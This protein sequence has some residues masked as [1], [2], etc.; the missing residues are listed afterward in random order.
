MDDWFNLAIPMDAVVAAFFLQW[1]GFLWL[2][3][4]TDTF[5][6]GFYTRNRKRGIILGAAMFCLWGPI[7]LM[8]V[9]YGHSPL[10]LWGGAS[11]A[12]SADMGFFGKS[13]AILGWYA[14]LSPIQAII[15]IVLMRR[16]GRVH[17]TP[18]GQT[19]Q[20]LLHR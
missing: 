10:D 17:A 9:K 5:D 18:E 3:A 7:L 2:M 8:W 19:Y 16:R 13:I 20:K 14:L 15:A 4:A 1:P 11:A 6:L 12:W